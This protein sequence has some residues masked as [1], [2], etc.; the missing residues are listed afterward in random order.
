MMVFN[1]NLRD[2]RGSF[3]GSMLVFRGVFLGGLS[4]LSPASN[5]VMTKRSYQASYNSEGA[6]IAGNAAL[7]GAT[8]G[9]APEKLKIPGVNQVDFFFE[10]FIYIYIS[11]YT[12]IYICI[13]GNE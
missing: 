10:R 13:A 3:S 1:R 5:A 9:K 2:S 6:I 11:I 12:Y 4:I 8:A 7:Y